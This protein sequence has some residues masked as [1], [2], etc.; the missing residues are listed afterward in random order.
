MEAIETPISW[1]FTGQLVSLVGLAWLAH[2]S[3]DMP[4]WQSTVAVVLSYPLS[5]VACRV[6]GETDFTPNGAMGKVTQL[7]FGMLNPGN[8]NVNLMSA[9]ITTGASGSAAKTC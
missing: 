4:W 3:F 8:M 7:T 1:F 2:A 5:L 6:T 9:N